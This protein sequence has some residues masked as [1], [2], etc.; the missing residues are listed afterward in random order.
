MVPWAEPHGRFTL[1]MKRLVI[2]VF[3]ACHNVNGACTLVGVT[4]NQAW[5]VL[6]RA[7]ARSH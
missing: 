5:H 1:L 4:W 2:D 6:E 7:V 3:Q